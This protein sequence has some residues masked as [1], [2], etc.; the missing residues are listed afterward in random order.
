VVLYISAQVL[1]KYDMSS[2]EIAATFKS[3]DIDGT[4]KIG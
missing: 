1:E 2:D 4:G 3:I